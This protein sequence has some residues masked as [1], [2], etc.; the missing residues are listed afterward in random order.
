MFVHLAVTLFEVAEA[1]VGFAEALVGF[2][3]A[4]LDLEKTLLSLNL[5]LGEQHQHIVQSGLLIGEHDHQVFQALHS[6]A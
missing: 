1:L 5:C 2:A 4:L 3:E 6:S